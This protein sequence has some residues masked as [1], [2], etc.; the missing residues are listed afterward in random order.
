MNLS[1][2]R[3]AALTLTTVFVVLVAA[4]VLAPSALASDVDDRPPTLA[5]CNKIKA[6]AMKATGA[7]R[8]ALLRQ[9]ARCK[10]QY[11]AGRFAMAAFTNGHYTG[12]RSDGETVDDRYC[13]NG[14]W[15]S[16][17][18]SEFGD[19]GRGWYITNVKVVGTNI[20]RLFMTAPQG[21]NAYYQI[22]Y[23]RIGGTWEVGIAFGDGYSWGPVTRT[24]AAS[25][26]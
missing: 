25:E 16:D 11:D 21:P 23:R 19:A 2:A 26:C 20:M 1:L 22:A 24:N 12:A 7:K 18:N 3:H 4:T 10:K 8:T 6:Q 9:Y 13:R 5:S 15:A 14:K 17:V